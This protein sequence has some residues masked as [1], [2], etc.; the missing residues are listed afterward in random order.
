MPAL[1]VTGTGTEIGK[2]F[3][4]AGLI[5]HLRAA[6]R[7]VRA[8]KPVISGFDA[9][10]APASDSALLLDAL[11]IP[12]CDEAIA[13]IS[14]WRYAAPLSPNMA[15]RAEGRSI[16]LEEVVA[17]CRQEISAEADATVLI[18]GVGGLMV[19]L[20]E[21]RTVLDWIARLNIPTLL[22]AG[23]YLGAISHTLTC[24]EVLRSRRLPLAAVLVNESHAGIALQPTVE[25]IAAFA[26]P[27]AVLALPRD[28]ADSERHA[29]YEQVLSLVS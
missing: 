3:V 14:P 16:D 9:M 21:R 17:F 28:A 4:C 15:A 12:L 29:V 19:P 27:S 11:G 1:F 2:T 26:A 25:T 23:S 10:T 8:L 7:P 22:I 20:D 5:R 6:L 24:V 18:E 13:A